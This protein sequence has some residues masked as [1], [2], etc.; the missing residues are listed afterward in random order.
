VAVVVVVLLVLLEMRAVQ[1]VVAAVKTLLLRWQVVQET[2]QAPLQVK[3]IL[4]VMAHLHRGVAMEVA[5]AVLAL[6]EATL[7]PMEVRAE[8]EPRLQLPALLWLTLAAVV[9]VLLLGLA[10]LAG[11]AVVV[12]A[13]QVLVL[14]ATVQATLAAVAAV[15]LIQP[16]ATAA[17]VL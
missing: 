2:P 5:A 1:A 12:Q 8:M 4:A 9:V 14:A 11:R 3:E 16:V 13:Q 7:H 17:R 6:L 15:E 10:L